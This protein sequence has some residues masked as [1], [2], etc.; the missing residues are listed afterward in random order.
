MTFLAFLTA[1]AGAVLVYDVLDLLWPRRTPPS[2]WDVT[3]EGERTETETERP[4][5]AWYAILGVVFPTWFDPQRARTRESVEDLIRRAGYHPYDS[6]ES[7]YTAAMMEFGK[8]LV[9]AAFAAVVFYQADMR[10]LVPVVAAALLWLAWRRP[11]VN[12]RKSAQARARAMRQNMLPGLAQMEALLDAGVGVQ[13][14]LRRT[15]NL[16]GPFCNLLGFLVARMEVEGVQ[17]AFRTVERHVPD[18]TDTNLMLFLQ[19]VEAYFLQQR[20]LNESVRALRLA[21]HRDL[22]NATRERAALVK[23]TAGLFGIFAVVGMVVALL[24]PLIGG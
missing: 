17:E 1:L 11:Y 4:S 20:P 2:R 5:S 21:V 16:G 6:P 22:V 13:E 7:F 14:A 8:G 15:A 24:L 10:P 19:D 3:I 23:R 12:L 18:P 9:K